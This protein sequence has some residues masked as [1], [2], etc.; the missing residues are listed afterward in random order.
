MKFNINKKFRSGLAH[1]RNAY[2]FS[3]NVYCKISFSQEG[4]DRILSCLLDGINNGFYVDVGAHHPKRFSNTYLLY[5]QGWHGI[6]ID[7]T[8]GSMVTFNRIRKRD[9]NLELAIGNQDKENIFYEFDEPAINSFDIN[10][11]SQHV[12]EGYPIV[13]QT[14]IHPKP[15]SEVLDAY[16]LANQTINLLSIDVEGLDSEVLSSNNWD[17]YRPSFVLVEDLLATNY[18][19]IQDS[20]IRKFMLEKKYDL[21]CKT[22]RTFIYFDTLVHNEF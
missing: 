19:R 17:K 16:L 15:L 5:L 8:P 9:I 18:Q 2:T 7:A 12:K 14:I 10:V 4:E 11:V 13:K 21:I 22:I 3:S 6:N 20:S 1:L